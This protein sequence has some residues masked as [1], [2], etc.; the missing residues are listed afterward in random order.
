M[1]S[2]ILGHKDKIIIILGVI[3]SFY[4]LYTINL[5]SLF[6]G[7]NLIKL[8][9]ANAIIEND[10]ISEEVNCKII[11]EFGGCKYLLPNFNY[12]NNKLIGPF[13]VYQSYLIAFIVYF[14]S[15][16]FLPYLSII[17][18]FFIL[19]ILYKI[20]K[21]ETEILFIF[22][23]STPI[24]FHFL[25]FLDVA[26]SVFSITLSLSIIKIE[27][28]KLI[29]SI[30]GFLSGISAWFRPESLI[31]LIFFIM[32]IFIFHLKIKN[33]HYYLF[34]LLSS[35]I[36]YL[37]INY[38]NYNSILGTRI[39]ANQTEIFNF[40]IL[41]KLKIIKSLL[42]Y[43]D[44]R[45][46]TFGYMPYLLVFILIYIINIKDIPQKFTVLFASSILS[47][48]TISIFSP[49]NSNIDWGSRYI[50]T[51]LVPLLLSFT[52]IN[53]KHLNK[54]SKLV[55]SLLL[56]YSIS[57]TLKYYNYHKSMSREVIKI[58]QV[59]QSQNS[60]LW[61]FTNQA[62]LNFSNISIVS[63]PILFL[64]DSDDINELLQMIQDQSKI[65]SFSFFQINPM[66]YRYN[67]GSKDYP[68]PFNSNLDYENQ[69]INQFKEKFVLISSNE[70]IFINS[71]TFKIK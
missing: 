20:W 66:F 3:F 42:I 37:I 44:H 39:T 41:I 56:I 58:D 7:D 30:I 68:N 63:Q 62:L 25:G 8:V 65:D 57:I 54:I 2:R 43:G 33:I 12:I 31:F 18:F 21:I 29:I 59:F 28:S 16:T 14:F 69:L 10:F 67:P 4:I 9:Q 40:D 35:L 61:I 19:V 11:K 38:N 36:L 53:K 26:I 34:F 1:I 22:F 64:K 23:L 46:G 27:M 15:P 6:I 71:Y 70:D 5:K 60:N 50:T 51:S 24:F 49:N 47:I 55:L 52:A 32:L 17:L 48:V 13:P 45:Y